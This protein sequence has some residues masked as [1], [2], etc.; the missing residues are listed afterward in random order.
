MATC[1]AFIDANEGLWDAALKH[2]FLSECKNATI[3]EAQFN[4]WLVQVHISLAPYTI[5]AQLDM[6]PK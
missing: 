3:S 4:T 6:S 2:R 1:K 5:P